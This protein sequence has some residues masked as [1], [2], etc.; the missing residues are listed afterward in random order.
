MSIVHVETIMKFPAD[1][2]SHVKWHATNEVN[3]YEI[4]FINIT[5]RSQNIEIVV[6]QFGPM[7]PCC[8]VENRNKLD[9][10]FHLSP[11]M[12]IL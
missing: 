10:T 3:M 5:P 11:F 6:F 1:E 2:S 9:K 8:R 4:A 12:S 7:S